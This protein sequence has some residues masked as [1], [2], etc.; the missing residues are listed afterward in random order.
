MV[1]QCIY[2]NRKWKK[3]E[4]DLILVNYYGIFV[5]ESKN[6]TGRL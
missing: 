3:T 5:I 2:T 1:S 6:W 4:I